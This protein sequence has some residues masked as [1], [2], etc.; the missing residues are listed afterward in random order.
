MNNDLQ[1]GEQNKKKKPMIWTPET[2]LKYP[3]YAF[4]FNY[5][6]YITNICDT[7]FS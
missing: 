6:Q 4:F 5:V 1:L 2:M 7:F 3:C